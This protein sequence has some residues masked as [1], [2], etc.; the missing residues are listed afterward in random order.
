[1]L[2]LISVV[3]RLQLLVNLPGSTALPEQ[4]PAEIHPRAV[5]PWSERIA[6]EVKVHSRSSHVTKWPSQLLAFMIPARV[7]I[8]KFS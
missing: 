5:I 4:V 1:M 3:S 2:L 8:P 6:G 7:E